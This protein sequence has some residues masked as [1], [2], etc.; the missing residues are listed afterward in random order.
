MGVVFLEYL[1]GIC[2][3]ECTKCKAFLSNCT[4]LSKKKCIHFLRKEGFLLDKV[5]NVT[6]KDTKF[7]STLSGS[8]VVSKFLHFF[9]F[10]LHVKN[11]FKP[12]Y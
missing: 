6:Y 9:I 2:I 1:G 3:F 10:D 4:Y 7:I 11:N 5:V 8:Y 12:T